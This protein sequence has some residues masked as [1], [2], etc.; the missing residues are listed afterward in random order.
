[1]KVDELIGSLKTFEVAINEKSKSKFKTI[2]FVS[3]TGDGETKDYDAG[4]NLSESISLIRRQLNKVIQRME[5]KSGTHVGTHVRP[6]QSNIS[7][8]NSTPKKTK[9]EDQ[10]NQGGVQCNECEGYGHIRSECPNFIKRQKGLKV[11]W[12]DGDSETE[13]E[14]SKHTRALTGICTSDTDSDDEISIETLA[15]S[16]KQLCAK[17]EEVSQNQRKTIV[18][19]QGKKAKLLATVSEL[20]KEKEDFLTTINNLEVE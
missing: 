3:N 5:K 19:L 15:N 2:A 18:A 7:K 13:S 9:E 20:R 11:S 1:M 4:E 6:I 10:G 16:Y 8:G 17:N 12:S 14:S